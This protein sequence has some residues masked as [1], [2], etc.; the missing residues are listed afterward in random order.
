MNQLLRA[1]TGAGGPSEGKLVVRISDLGRL[2]ARG[3]EAWYF[4]MLV[5]DSLPFRGQS[6]TPLRPIH[7]PRIPTSTP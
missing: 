1:V 4:G 2:M 7:A 3:G 5:A 6:F